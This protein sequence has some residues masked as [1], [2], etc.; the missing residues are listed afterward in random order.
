VVSRLVA[1]V[2]LILAACGSDGSPDVPDG[3][4]GFWENKILA[5]GAEILIG[6]KSY[7]GEAPAPSNQLAV[8]SRDGQV[9]FYHPKMGV[10]ELNDDSSRRAITWFAA[11]PP[12][13]KQALTEVP[14]NAN[15]LSAGGLDVVWQEDTTTVRFENQVRRWSAVTSDLQPE[16]IYV[17]PRGDVIPTSFT[18]AILGEIAGDL[19]SSSVVQVPV[20]VSAL[21]FH[22]FIRGLPAAGTFPEF[23]AAVSLAY[24]MN[25][26]VVETV[27]VV[28]TVTLMVQGAEAILGF[29]PFECI[30][31]ISFSTLKTL[32]VELIDSILGGISVQL[33]ETLYKDRVTGLLSEFIGCA[34]TVIVG[35]LTGGI[36]AIAVEAYSFFNQT[37]SLLNFAFDNVLVGAYENIKYAPFDQIILNRSSQDLPIVHHLRVPD[38]V[39][40]RPAK[41]RFEIEVENAESVSVWLINTLVSQDLPGSGITSYDAVKDGSRLWVLDVD[42]VPTNPTFGYHWLTVSARSQSGF[43]VQQ[44]FFFLVPPTRQYTG[45]FSYSYVMTSTEGAEYR[46]DLDGVLELGFKYEGEETPAGLLASKNY[47]RVRVDLSGGTPTLT[48]PSQ[49][50]QSSISPLISPNWRFGTLRFGSLEFELGPDTHTLERLEGVKSEVIPTQNAY[51]TR[52]TVSFSADFVPMDPPSRQQP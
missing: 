26:S 36:G 48:C 12:A 20:N 3:S 40:Q 44:Q 14:P 52:E 28:D 46:C 11:D 34:Q 42:V 23:A 35:A 19:A 22:S 25:R 43:E 7:Q 38:L 2:F 10:R 27:N 30:D 51:T 4:A 13:L 41:A 50:V 1:F 21:T 37:I 6:G 31:A 45:S 32:Q 18:D 16:S 8:I 29:V 15:T 24:A 5:P 9:F 49:V 17:A 33:K 47:E 39:Q